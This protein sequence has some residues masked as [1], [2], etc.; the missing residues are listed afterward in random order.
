VTK[1]VILLLKSYPPGDHILSDVPTFYYIVAEIDLRTLL[2]SWCVCP[3]GVYGSPAS[4]LLV[5]ACV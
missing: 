4:Y 5:V 2:F 3:G 1:S